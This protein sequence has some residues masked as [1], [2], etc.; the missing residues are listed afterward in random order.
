MREFRRQYWDSGVFCS[1]LSK[2]EGR[3]EIVLDLLKEAHA[4][5]IEIISTSF[6]LVEVLKLKAH[7]NITGEVLDKLRTFFEYPFIKIVNADREICE[8]ARS[9]V[10]K[11]GMKAK[12]A[13]H[14]ATAEVASRVV[15]IH[16]VFSWDDDF[17]RLYGETPLKIPISHPFMEQQVLRL[18]TDDTDE[19]EEAEP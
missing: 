13:V 15:E 2:E 3:Y 1:F 8:L 10:W 9:Y 12:D 19:S 4:G 16:R 14:M 11:H 17:V 7:G 18:D 5:R 6:A